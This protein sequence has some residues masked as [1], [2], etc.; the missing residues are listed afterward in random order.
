MEAY[1]QT[2]RQEDPEVSIH[3]PAR[4]FLV[5]KGQGVGT[6]LLLGNV[7]PGEYRAELVPASLAGQDWAGFCEASCAA[8]QHWQRPLAELRVLTSRG[9]GSACPFFTVS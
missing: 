4:S 6:D 8:G 1:P 3:R 9:L 5:R 7:Q 2:R